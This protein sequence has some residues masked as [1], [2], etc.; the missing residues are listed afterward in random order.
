VVTDPRPKSVPRLWPP[1]FSSVEP[2]ST[3]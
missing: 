2:W 3:G 1:G